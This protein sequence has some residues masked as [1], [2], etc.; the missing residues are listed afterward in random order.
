MKA[1]LSVSLV[2][3]V[4]CTVGLSQAIAAPNAAPASE[5]A[6]QAAER[7]KRDVGGCHAGRPGRE[8]RWKQLDIDGDGSVSK[9]EAEKGA[10]RLA[11]HFAQIDANSDGKLTQEEMCNAMQARREQCRQDPERCRA[12]MKQRFDAAWKQADTDGDGALSR[13]E[14]E[15][16][17][18]R[19]ARHFDKIDTDHDSRVTTAEM[20]AA[21]ARHPHP[22]RP[23]A[24]D[25]PPAAPRNNG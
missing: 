5:A 19:L 1:K 18:P 8:S 11:E 12:D 17:M 9:S 4:L 2:T 23:P 20:D 14:A 25:A 16:G 10:P 22:K 3:A 13:S 15:K 24:P 21:R 7:G 6:A